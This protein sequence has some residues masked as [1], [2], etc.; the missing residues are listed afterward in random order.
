[1]AMPMRIFCNQV[2]GRAGAW[3]LAALAAGRAV[4][5]N[6]GDQALDRRAH[7]AVVVAL[8]AAAAPSRR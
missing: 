2:S 8:L 1:M 7:G 4:A 5:G 3:A 6:N